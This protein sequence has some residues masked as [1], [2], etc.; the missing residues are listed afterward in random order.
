M[1]IEQ[2][3]A[4]LM[5]NAIKFTAPG[6]SVRLSLAL[7]DMGGLHALICLSDT[8]IGI[9]QGDLE[10]I[11]ERHFKRYPADLDREATGSG[12]GLAISKEIVELHE[13]KIWMEDNG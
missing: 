2:V 6:G 8:G 1:R 11:F 4:N 13:G 9:P 5:S 7:G 10:R 3:L 12:L